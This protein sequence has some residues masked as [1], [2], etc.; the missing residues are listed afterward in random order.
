MV[1]EG[2]PCAR[3]TIMS[4]DQTINV[5]AS[6]GG[7]WP[8]GRWRC[9]SGSPWTLP[10]WILFTASSTTSC[11]RGS[12]LD[13]FQRGRAC[14]RRARSPPSSA[15]PAL[16]WLRR[17][18]TCSPKGIWK[19]GSGRV[20]T[21]PVHCP[22]RCSVSWPDRTGHIPRS[23]GGASPCEE[24]CLRQREPPRS[25][26]REHRALSGP[27]CP[28]STSF[29]TGCGAGSRVACGGGRKEHCSVTVTLPGTGRCG[30][31]YRPT[32]RRRGP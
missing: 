18:R 28:R 23:P 29:L 4:S 20:P 14:L 17:S 15:Y 25:R 22:R 7:T 12:S 3:S 27:A 16:R 26:T 1:A 30:G 31:R 5:R 11:A 2:G 13:N 8:R 9:R 21:S 32:S 6:G 19:E 24:P 10:R